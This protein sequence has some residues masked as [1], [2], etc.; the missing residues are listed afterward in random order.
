MAS[1]G[2]VGDSYDNALAKSI[3]GLHKAEVMNRK[4]FKNQ[5]D[6]ELTT[7]AQVGGFYNRR[8][9]GCIGYIP[10]V[11]ADKAYYAFLVDR[12]LVA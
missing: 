5:H 2:S 12:E 8:L 3:N 4:R 6:V 10:P 1:T 7:L 11:K 9:P